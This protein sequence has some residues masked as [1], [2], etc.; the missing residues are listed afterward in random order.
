[1]TFGNVTQVARAVSVCAALAGFGSASFAQDPPIPDRFKQLANSEFKNDYPVPA[2]TNSLL[3][4]LYFQRA[5]MVYH[6]ALPA[7]NM[8]AMKEGADKAYGQ[9]YNVMSIWKKRLDAKTLITTPNSDVIYGVGF[10]DV[11]K[12]GPMVID[13]PPNLQAILD[14]YWQRPI[15]GPTVDGRKYLGDVGQ[16]GPDKGKGGKYLVLPPGYKGQVPKGYY[17]YHSRTNGVFVFLRGF[18]DRPD[19]LG[20]AVKNMEGIKIYPLGKSASAKPMQFPDVSGIAVNMVPPPDGS[21]FDMLNRFI[22][23]EVTDYP[24]SEYMRGV[25]ASIGIVKGQDF[26]PTPRQ[27]EMLDLAARTAWKMAKVVATEQFPKMPGAKWYNNRQWWGHIRDGGKNFG[28]PIDD[29]NYMVPGA[30]YIDI[31][32]QLH[33]FINYYAMSPGMG[34]S[35]PGV[36]SKYLVGAKDADGDYLVGDGNYT[37]TLPPNIPAKN[38]WSVTLYDPVT[39]AGLDN[40]QPFP[41]LNSRDNP[42]KNADGSTTLYFGPAAPAGKEK[43]WMKTVPGKGWF[44]LLRLYGPEKPFFDQAWVPGDFQKVR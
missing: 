2:T 31:D 32:P 15:E 35:V 7:V 6:W 40:G 3:D 14:D 37:L 33:M 39:A 1:M 10:L 12:D 4:E 28:K 18:F 44:T 38:F 29:F 41:S 13:A 8:Y 43:N 21:Y 19:N 16:P 27:K 42:V 36:G 34:T 20:P 24:S 22:Q 17:V 26:A 30:D 5:V 9:G 23:S 25:A 11:A